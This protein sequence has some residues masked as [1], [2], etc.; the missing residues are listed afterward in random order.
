MRSRLICCRRLPLARTR[1][2]TPSSLWTRRVAEQ[3]IS[4][5]PIRHAPI[6]TCSGLHWNKRPGYEWREEETE[7]RCSDIERLWKLPVKKLAFENPKGCIP[8]RLGQKHKG[9]KRYQVVQ[10][11][12]FGHDASKGTCIWSRDEDGEPLPELEPTV[13]FPGSWVTDPR[14]GKLV[15]RWS[16]QTDSGQN[17]YRLARIAGFSVRSPIQGSRR[18]WS[19]LGAATASVN[20]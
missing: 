17:R 18:R 13:R 3:P 14:N 6:L 16:N 4:P 11:Y 5:S 15:E 2:W 8:T 1:R 7:K 9:L 10:P 12:Q 20:R 19:R